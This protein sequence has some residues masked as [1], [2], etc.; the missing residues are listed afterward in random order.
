MK[1]R[2]A[3]HPANISLSIISG[4]P[5]SSFRTL[6]CCYCVFIVNEWNTWSSQIHKSVSCVFAALSCRVSWLPGEAVRRFRQHAFPWEIL[7]LEAVHWWWVQDRTVNPFG[8]KHPYMLLRGNCSKAVFNVCDS[9]FHTSRV[10]NPV[11]CQFVEKPSKWPSCSTCS[12]NSVLRSLTPA[13]S[14]ARPT[15]FWDF[16]IFGRA[17]WHISCQKPPRGKGSFFGSLLDQHRAR[18]AAS[19]IVFNHSYWQEF[20]SAG[21][22]SFSSPHF[23]P[24]CLQIMENIHLTENTRESDKSSKHVNTTFIFFE[25]WKSWSWMSFITGVCFVQSITSWLAALL[26]PGAAIYKQQITCVSVIVVGRLSRLCW[27]Q[28]Y[29]DVRLWVLDLS[30]ADFHSTWLLL[31]TSVVEIPE[32]AAGLGDSTGVCWSACVVYHSSLR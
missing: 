25:R 22:L 20:R 27:C 26:G 6:R 32:P 10:R 24:W 18:S 7:Q 23:S 28:C 9:W 4:N 14:A 16:Y 11:S 21:L 2:E 3:N 19:A 8:Q 1:S 12:Q 31:S 13:G 30:T 29:S 15:W 5:I 17:S